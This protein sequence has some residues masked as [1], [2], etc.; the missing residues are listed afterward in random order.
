MNGGVV[1]QKTC[2]GWILSG[3]KENKV[4]MNSKEHNIITLHITRI[5]K[6]DNDMLRKLW[7][8]ETESCTKKKIFTKEEEMCE[9]KYI[10]IQQKRIQ[11][12][13]CLERKFVKSEVLKTEY[14][15]VIDEYMDMGH[16]KKVETIDDNSSIYLP[17]PAVIREDKETS[18][19][20]VVYDAS[21]KGSNGYSL[22]DCMMTSV[23]T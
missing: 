1:S 6:E 23:T 8:I 22:N 20:R 16:M 7:E 15:K 14:S 18:K 21:A 12:F 10:K 9:K 11:R 3:Q 19:V 13:Q 2:L 5:V 17:H 4:T